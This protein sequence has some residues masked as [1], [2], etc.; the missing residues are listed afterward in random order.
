MTVLVAMATALVFGLYPSLRAARSDART[1]LAEGSRGIAG[2]RSQWPRRLLVGAEVALG[3]VLVV[4]AGLLT[5]TFLHLRQLEPGFDPDHVVA[6]SV[7]LQDARYTTTASMN[8]LF[9]DTLRRVRAIPGV[10]SAGVGLHVP[11]ERWL[12][13]N[14]HRLDGP[15]NEGHLSN[16]NYVTPGYFAALRVPVLAGRSLGESDTVD[17]SHVA[18]VNRAFAKRYF[19]GENPIGHGFRIGDTS[20]FQIVGIVGDVQQRS[21]W[22]GFGPIGPAPAIYVPASQL[23]DGFTFVH[24][25][26]SPSWVVRT[27][28]DVP[29]ARD[30]AR[31][32]TD[33]DAMMPVAAFH[34]MDDLRD[35]TLGAE[36]LQ[37]LLLGLLASLALVLAAVGIGGLIATSVAERRREMGIRLALG[38]TGARAVLTAALPGWGMTLAGLA[39]GLALA[40]MG[41]HVLDSLTSGVPATDAVTFAA[42][43]ALL[44]AVGAVASLVPALRLLTLDPIEALRD[45]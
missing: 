29:V 7:S 39:A 2:G 13:I 19:K 37:A 33:V 26:F 40:R 15:D 10:E 11:Y 38:S 30:I 9:E 34:S 8:R 22:G 21:G 4:G 44:L 43:A 45:E 18:V 36:R 27:A 6:A 24:T 25:W 17:S 28:G 1:G 14:M 16:L 23:P 12:N 31:A 5:R 32:I 42:A 20:S 3:I 41:V 35:L